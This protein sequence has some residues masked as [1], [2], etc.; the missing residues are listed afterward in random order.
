MGFRDANRAQAIQVGAI[1]LF[2]ILILG[3]SIYQATVVPQQN[4]RV[5][6]NAYQE[7]T[8]DMVSVRND[9]VA[10]GTEGT[11]AS[12]TV[13]TGATYPARSIFINPG[14]P[15]G[16]ISTEGAPNVSVDGV[17]AVE[18][19]AENTQTFWNATSGTYATNRVTFTP[20]YNEFD[21]S[22]VTVAGQGVYRLPDDRV[23][24]ISA[25][26][27]IR[28]NR[29]TL[30]TVRGDLGA[31][32]GS[33]PVTADPV[34]TATRTVVVTGTGATFDV[35]V[36]TPIPASAWNDT[37]APDVVANPNVVTTTPVGDESVR[38]TFNGSRQYELRLAAVEL[39]AQ[40]DSS[41][42]ERPGGSYLIGLTGNE[43]VATGRARPVVA[44][45]RDRYNNP[46]SG[47][48]VTFEVVAG[49]GS[50]ANGGTQRTV[51]TD[52]NGRAPVAL[53]PDSSGTITVEAR[54]D[55]NGNG[56]IEPYERTRF[57]F[58][59]TAGSTDDGGAEEINPSGDGD[60]VL[61]KG[62]AKKDGDIDLY[63]NNTAGSDRTV[64]EARVSFYYTTSPSNGQG[65][66][67][68]PPEKLIFGN[69]KFQV[70]GQL[71]PLDS[72]VTIPQNSPDAIAFSLETPDSGTQA[73]PED[74]L[75]LTLKFQE[76]GE[77]STYF[78]TL[79]GN[80]NNGNPGGGNGGGRGP[81]GNGPPGQN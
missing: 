10:A 71:K 12:T 46:V 41:T 76:T 65:N 16:T 44:E 48:E 13:A 36:P 8:D 45:V 19:E 75:V 78:I 14:A 40:S 5:E 39:R 3:I 30:V 61:V 56:N 50:F 6:F 32:G 29:I 54:S 58:T 17:R 18:S 74:F 37:V 20:S 62:V 28:G 34:S 49:G 2:G 1:L 51:T 24:P 77:R 55:L 47:E 69:T 33:V 22:P 38:I 43:T 64:S 73:K 21:G 53:R 59:A 66:T 4:A 80:D 79:E 11:S 7:A 70:P 63:F 60:V 81:S 57:G 52:G 72:P 25:G 42:V 31:A 27:S 23:L 26:S 15:A 67:R 35:T 9:V 68:Q